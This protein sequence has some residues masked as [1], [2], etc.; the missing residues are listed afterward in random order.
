MFVVVVVVYF[1][2]LFSFG[3][4]LQE[5]RMDMKEWGDER[6]LGYMM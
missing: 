3:E 1:Y 6:D 2:F 4:R 5:P